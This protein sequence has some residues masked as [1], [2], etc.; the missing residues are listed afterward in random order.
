MNIIKRKGGKRKGMK[1]T[2]MGIKGIPI[3]T[4]FVFRRRILSK[5]KIPSLLKKSVDLSSI[6]NEAIVGL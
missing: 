3:F 2:I 6:G 1:R 4:S 5:D